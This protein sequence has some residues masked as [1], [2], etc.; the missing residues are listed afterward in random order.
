[1]TITYFIEE[2][3]KVG[4]FSFTGCAGDQLVIIHDED[5]L[6]HY[7][8]QADIKS[9]ILANSESDD[10]CELDIALVEGSINTEHEV[11]ELK[12]IRK[13]TKFL[14]AIGSCAMHGGFQSG[15]T[16]EGQWMD[17]YKSI[18][19][20]HIQL[21]KAIEPQ[22]LSSHVKVDMAIPGCPIDSDQ[23]YAA[24]SEIV[25]GLKPEIINSP[26]CQECRIRENK[27]MLED[28][29]LCLGPITSAGCKAACPTNNVPCMGCYGLYEGGNLQGFFKMGYEMGYSQE[30]IIRRLSCHGG[31]TTSRKLKELNIIKGGSS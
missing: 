17:R 9:F 15:F 7:F 30:E 5:R 25:H 31:H 3:V 4:I 19:G 27:C 13:R 2:K 18:Y 14:V 1:M 6:L 16:V 29:I 26:V 8:S 22:P 12:N 21:T 28:G 24:F 23:I 20:D 11:E 10:D